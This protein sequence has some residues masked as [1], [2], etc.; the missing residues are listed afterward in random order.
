MFPQPIALHAGLQVCHCDASIELDQV[1]H[2]KRTARELHQP[3]ADR[4]RSEIEPEEAEPVDK[5]ADLGLR[6]A[7]V[8]GIE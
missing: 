1:V 3:C 8:T 6:G 4:E 5:R 2:G 7:F